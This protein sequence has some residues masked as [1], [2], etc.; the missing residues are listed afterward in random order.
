MSKI[1]LICI[2]GPS[3]S[4]KSTIGKLTGY[5]LLTCVTTRAPRPGEVP[6]KDYDFVTWEEYQRMIDEGELWEHVINYGTGY[7]IHKKNIQLVLNS[8]HPYHSVV[9][10]EGYQKLMEFMP[11]PE[12][13]KAVFVYVPKEEIFNRMKARGDAAIDIVKR[14]ETYEAEV[15]T[16]R[17]CDYVV[18]NIEGCIDQSVATVK[19]I[20]EG[21]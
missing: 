16:A 7:G 21:I 1:K 5:P 19:R 11:E 20:V 18:A 12:A 17:E 4:G 8:D 14:L 9:T 2:V 3:G 10:I 13:M 15:A 6:G